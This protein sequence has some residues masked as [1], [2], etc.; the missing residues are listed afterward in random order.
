MPTFDTNQSRKR[1]EGIVEAIRLARRREQ[2]EL[3]IQT[4][5][6]DVARA[7]ADDGH[8]LE[9]HPEFIGR[10]VV[11]LAGSSSS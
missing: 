3:T 4:P 6:G 5:P 8:A 7:L 10:S 11:R 9:A 2:G 1:Y